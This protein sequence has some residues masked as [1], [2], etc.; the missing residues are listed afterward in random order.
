VWRV[1]VW[2][3]QAADARAQGEQFCLKYDANSLIY[4]SKA[5]DLFDLSASALAE[6][7]LDPASRAPASAAG[8]SR[9]PSGPPRAHP[10][11]VNPPAHL[12]DLAAGLAPL[13]HTPT[14]VLGVQSDILFPPE[15]QREIADALRMAGNGRVSYYE[16]GGVWG[17]DTFL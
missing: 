15:Q 11:P 6:L 10:P 5:M 12:A 8:I 7:G 3:R 1:R 9:S 14:L 17:H 16:L 2:R 13:A 4:V